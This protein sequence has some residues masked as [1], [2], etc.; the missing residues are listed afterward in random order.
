VTTPL[1]FAGAYADAESGLL[2][3]VNRY[4][5]PETGQFLSVDPAV[6]ETGQPYGYANEDPLN[7][8]DPL[9]LG[10]CLLGHNPDGGCRGSSEAQSAV[11][12]VAHVASDAVGSTPIGIAA[13]GVSDLTGRSISICAGASSYAGVG[14]GVQGCWVAS[15]S[16]LQGFTGTVEGGV[17]YGTSAFVGIQET[18]AQCPGELGGKFSYEEGSLGQGVYA[19]GG[20][21]VGGRASDG[22]QISGWQGGWAPGATPVSGDGGYSYTWTGGESW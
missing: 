1:Q 17:G 22:R 3:L 19:V 7:G 6:T 18:N 14:G 8:V 2:Y 10:F 21:H 20:G 4:Y 16:G 9:G 15:P 5:D 11:R 12:V 13:Q